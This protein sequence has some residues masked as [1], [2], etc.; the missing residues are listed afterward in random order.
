ML[1][2]RPCVCV[3]ADEYVIVRYSEDRVESSDVCW[4]VLLN[5][6]Y[7]EIVV[8]ERSPTVSMATVKYGE[9]N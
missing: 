4:V 5:W 2:S 3:S 9:R 1:H 8:N 6:K 7:A